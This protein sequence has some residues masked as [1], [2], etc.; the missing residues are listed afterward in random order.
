[1][2]A[3]LVAAFAALLAAP[4][5]AD[6]T[7]ELPLWPYENQG[8]FVQAPAKLVASPVYGVGFLAGAFVCLPATLVQQGDKNDQPRD[9]EFSLIC[10]KYAGAALGWPVY[11]AVGLPLFIVK[12][13]FW[14]FPKAVGRWISPPPPA[15]PAEPAPAAQ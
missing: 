14:E 9:K 15:P 12:Q 10:G 13:T 3:L 5:Y 6:T 1:M 8:G 2:R 4:A 11:A 7:P